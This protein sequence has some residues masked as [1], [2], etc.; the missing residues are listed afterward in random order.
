MTLWEKTRPKHT[1]KEEKQQ[2]VAKLLA[3]LRGKVSE[4]SS[5]HSA[6]RVIQ[7]CARHGA[8][9]ERQVIM[10]EVKGALVELSKS[11]HGHFLV[12]KLI[13]MSKKEEIPGEGVW[14]RRRAW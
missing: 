8:A 1:T 9:P 12:Q 3:N 11:K 4:L 5:N 2:L 13:N 6:S 14:G 7:F 10:A